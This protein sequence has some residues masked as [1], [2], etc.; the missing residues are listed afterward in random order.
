M[1][2]LIS[3]YALCEYPAVFGG[4]ACLSTHW[5]G[6]FST[7]NNHI[8]AAFMAYLRT[9]LPDPATH[10]L[11]FDYGTETL[12]ALY[13]PFQ[14]QA[15]SILREKGYSAANWQTLKFVGADHSERAWRTRLAIPLTFLMK[16]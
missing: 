9:H 2:G 14:L 8:P 11:Y 13:E 5:V 4:A 15:D 7:E 16:Q 10:R 12:D 6:I 1:G 3:M